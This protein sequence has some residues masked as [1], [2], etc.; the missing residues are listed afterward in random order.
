MRILKPG[1][2]TNRIWRAALLILM[3]VLCLMPQA[4]RP[5]TGFAAGGSGSIFV[6]LVPTLDSITPKGLHLELYQ[7]AVGDPLEDEA[8]FTKEFADCGVELSDYVKE[9]STTVS[10][11]DKWIRDKGISSVREATSDSNGTVCFS[12][13]E[14]GIYYIIHTNQKDTI[15]G[16]YTAQVRSSVVLIPYLE[17]GVRTRDVISNL[18]CRI[19]RNDESAAEYTVEKHWQDDNDKNKLR[20]GKI[21]IGLYCDEELVEKVWIS[22]ADNWQHTFTKL[23]PDREYTARELVVPKG[24][25]MKVSREDTTIV[26]T[27]RLSV[28]PPGG[29]DSAAKTGD[30]TLI[31]LSAALMA[32]ALLIIIGTILNGRRRK[33]NKPTA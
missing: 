4:V 22:A 8:V 14:D 19:L 23:D 27:N 3:V 12:N 18:K 26:I 21:Q 10:Q 24:Y 1:A 16:S 11:T 31:M 9:P 28:K 29:G 20:P 30:P 32:A 25:E 13:L 6:N 15:G 33:N 2:M 17:D 5:E 7:I